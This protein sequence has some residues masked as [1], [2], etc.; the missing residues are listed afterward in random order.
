MLHSTAQ[1]SGER[2]PISPSF[3]FPNTVPPIKTSTSDICVIGHFCGHISYCC[4]LH[5]FESLLQHLLLRCCHHLP[6]SG[7]FFPRGLDSI[8]FQL[9]T[10]MVILIS[11]PFPNNY[12]LPIISNQTFY[13]K[14]TTVFPACSLWDL[15]QQFIHPATSVCSSSHHGHSSFQLA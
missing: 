4:P 9:P 11:L 7:S 15:L 6:R 12:T 3:C 13:S 5:T 14:H 8:L 2:L 10:P 1:R